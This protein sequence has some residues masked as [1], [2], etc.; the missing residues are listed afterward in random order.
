MISYRFSKFEAGGFASPQRRYVPD[1][2]G[3]P[4]NGTPQAPAKS[5]Q[6]CLFLS[7]QHFVLHSLIA[8]HRLRRLGQHQHIHNPYLY[9]C[10][11]HGSGHPPWISS[12]KFHDTTV[13]PVM[14]P[15]YI[16]YFE[17]HCL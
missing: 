6:G 12:K 8:K 4:F 13:C 5:T 1:R 2:L 7:W 17:F 11:S 15:Q 10:T 9:R 14:I 3:V 16:D